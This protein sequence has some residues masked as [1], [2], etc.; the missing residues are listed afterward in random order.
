M[1]DVCFKVLQQ[2]KKK[3]KTDE[4][5]G[6]RANVVDSDFCSIYGRLWG[7]FTILFL[8]VRLFHSSRTVHVQWI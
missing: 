1:F 2:L 7:H 4:E 5:G 6:E 3:K 8:Y